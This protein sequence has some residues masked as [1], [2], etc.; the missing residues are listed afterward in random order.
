[1]RWQWKRL[2]RGSG[3]RLWHKR[4]SKLGTDHA[5]AIAFPLSSSFKS[6]VRLHFSGPGCLS[7][8]RYT[9]GLSMVRRLN[10]VQEVTG[11]SGVLTESMSDL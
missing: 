8:Q 11:D 1:M 4:L 3:N 6:I 10:D 5:R 2:G 9:K 7:A